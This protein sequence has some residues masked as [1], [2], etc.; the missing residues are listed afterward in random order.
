M[1]YNFYDLF[2]PDRYLVGHEFR[3]TV[4]DSWNVN[5]GP[6][7]VLVMES[8]IAHGS[9]DFFLRRQLRG[10]LIAGPLGRIGD[11]AAWARLASC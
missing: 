7:H 5:Y 6:Q 8:G 2:T 10:L 3:T 9:R 4:R 1:F 11:A